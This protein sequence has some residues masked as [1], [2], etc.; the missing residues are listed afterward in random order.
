MCTLM[1]DLLHYGRT[2]NSPKS[3]AIIQYLIKP[4]LS[5]MLLSVVLA[6]R[7]LPLQ[8]GVVVAVEMFIPLHKYLISHKI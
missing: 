3:S 5:P 7:T 2:I 8:H 6:G 1:P 4:Y